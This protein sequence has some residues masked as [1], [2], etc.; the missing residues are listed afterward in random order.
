MAKSTS[1]IPS[2]A[3]FILIAKYQP[4]LV[5]I[6][7]RDPVSLQTLLHAKSG[8]FLSQQNNLHPLSFFDKIEL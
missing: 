5:I 7:V 1:P 3:A 8:T 2:L 6:L 4:L